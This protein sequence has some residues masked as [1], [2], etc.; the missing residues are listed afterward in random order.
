MPLA[1][2]K[3]LS[4]TY[5]PQGSIQILLYGTQRPCFLGCLIFPKS[6]YQKH[7]LTLCVSV[8]QDENHTS[9]HSFLCWVLSP[10]SSPGSPLHPSCQTLD[11]TS[12]WSY[13]WTLLSQQPLPISNIV[14]ATLYSNYLHDWIVN[15]LRARIIFYS[16]S[17]P[18]YLVE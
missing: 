6:P 11:V 5:C 3:S 17:F 13:F 12:F 4:S 7:T 14:L 18:S 8:P 16:T 1:C 9:T 15:Y 10:C 2:L